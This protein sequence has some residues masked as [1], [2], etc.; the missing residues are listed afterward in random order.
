MT[1]PKR[2]EEIFQM[3]GEKF[4]NCE[5]SLRVYFDEQQENL[6]RVEAERDAVR[7]AMRRQSERHDELLS[8]L[9]LVTNQRAAG[10]PVYQY[11]DQSG[12]WIETKQAYYEYMKERGHSTR[13]LWTAPPPPTKNLSKNI[14][15]LLLTL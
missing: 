7:S 4:A 15:T 10:E 14:F 8:I 6:T 11:R 1:Y 9:E 12:E 2:I 13:I 5:S 3:I